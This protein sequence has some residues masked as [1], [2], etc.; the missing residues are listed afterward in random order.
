MC[1][2]RGPTFVFLFKWTKSKTLYRNVVPVTHFW[3]LPALPSTWFGRVEGWYCVRC[4][5]F[6]CL[7]HLILNSNIS[8]RVSLWNWTLPV[9]NKYTNKE[10]TLLLLFV[11]FFVLHLFNPSLFGINSIFVH[12]GKPPFLCTPCFVIAHKKQHTNQAC[13]T[14][15]CQATHSC[16]TRMLYVRGLRVLDRVRVVVDYTC[17]DLGCAC[18]WCC[19][20]TFAHKLE[21]LHEDGTQNLQVI[22]VCVRA[23]LVASLSFLPFFS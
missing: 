17:G 23:W 20:S 10:H 12:F 6:W 2:M 13:S 21:K 16:T 8:L 4:L 9:T 15:T 11:L 1:C 18:M 3:V 7:F 22:V 14:W 19:R 5:H